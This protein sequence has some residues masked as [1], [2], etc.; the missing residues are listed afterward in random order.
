M[1][2][3]VKLRLYV[4]L[5]YEA[6]PRNYGT[7]DPYEMARIDYRNFMEEKMGLED[8]FILC[9]E[10]DRVHVAIEPLLPSSPSSPSP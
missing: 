2:D 6:D 1:A 10:D 9:K 3:S 5:D 8:F 4:I 7:D